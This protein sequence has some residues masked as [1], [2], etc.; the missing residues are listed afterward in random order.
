[1]RAV[2]QRVTEA[3]VTVDG[4][5]VGSID[6]GLLV[7]L[8]VQKGDTE[9][10]LE[11]LANKIPRMRLFT[12]NEGK[13]N[14]SVSDLGY[15]VLVVSQFTLCADLRKGNRPSFDPAAEP[16]VARQMYGLFVEKVRSQGLEVATGEFG[17]SMR[18]AY[19]NEGPITLVL[20]SPGK[21]KQ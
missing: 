11:Y 12:D 4:T 9:V 1:M 19:T 20:D 2:I 7:Y 18:V 15:A 5:A 6:R 16:A 8:G 13:M 3:S 21:L 14:L 17:A 10:D